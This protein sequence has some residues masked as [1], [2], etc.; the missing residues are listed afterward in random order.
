M[1]DY[2]SD[3]SLKVCHQGSDPQTRE[4]NH[5]TKQ[6]MQHAVCKHLHMRC[7]QPRKESGAV[8]RSRY[9][10]HDHCTEVA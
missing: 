1:P 3:N 6:G 2:G 10:A 8:P 9:Q 5:C 4:V 7:R